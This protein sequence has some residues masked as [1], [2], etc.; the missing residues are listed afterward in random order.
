MHF[1]VLSKCVRPELTLCGLQD[2]KV[3]FTVA[4]SACIQVSGI[5]MGFEKLSFLL[6][7]SVWLQLH[8][9]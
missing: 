3:R 6:C 2:G 7:M 1:L 9:V 5:S 4:V 8:P